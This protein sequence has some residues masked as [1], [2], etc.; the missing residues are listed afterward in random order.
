MDR[1][2]LHLQSSPHIPSRDSTPKIMLSVF[3]ALLPAVAAGTYFFGYRALLVIFTSI[4]F[5]LI[6][7]VIF[8]LLRGRRPLPLDGSALLTGLLLGLCLP[9]KIPL[10]LV[11]LGAIIAIVLGKQIFGGLGHNIF[12]PALVGRAFLQASYPVIMTTWITPVE[13]WTADALSATTGATPLSGTTDFSY[14]ELFWGNTGGSIGETSA[15]AILI[16]GIFLLLIKNIDWRIPTGFLLSVTVFGGLLHLYDPINPTP[17]THLLTGGLLLGAFFMA[18]D[19]VTSPVS[20]TGS[21]IYAIAGGALVVI[22]RIFGG[23]PEGVMYSILL[24]NGFTP[25]IDRYTRAVP[26]GAV[27]TR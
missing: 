9:A 2:T 25:I 5:A 21:W 7:E 27:K 20:P 24:L 13:S 22:I 19:M 1:Q 23:P 11:A 3:L 17:L 26:F 18:T 8:L 10:T 6:T 12:N 15:F 14:A 4:F 16:G